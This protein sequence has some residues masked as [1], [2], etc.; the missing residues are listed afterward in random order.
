LTPYE[1]VDEAERPFDDVEMPLRPSFDVEM[2]STPYPFELVPET[3]GPE[4]VLLPETHEP[5]VAHE[6]ALAAVANALAAYA[7]G[8][9]VRSAVVANDETT[10]APMTDLIDMRTS[11]L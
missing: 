4:L 3:P 8:C 9:I 7:A 11:T 2:P 1:D 5:E 10:D 6:T